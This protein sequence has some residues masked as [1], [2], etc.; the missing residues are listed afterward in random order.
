M[1]MFLRVEGWNWGVV[2]LVGFVD[3]RFVVGGETAMLWL[4]W[5]M[6]EVVVVVVVVVEEDFEVV[7]V[8]IGWVIAGDGVDGSVAVDCCRGSRELMF[9]MLGWMGCR[10]LR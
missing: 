3:V 4:W 1:G 7:A 10:A 5:R 2:E 9:G 8:V 6:V